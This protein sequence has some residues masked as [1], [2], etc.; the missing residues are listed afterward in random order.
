MGDQATTQL[1]IFTGSTVEFNKTSGWEQTDNYEGTLTQCNLKQ[2]QLAAS[3]ATRIRLSPKGNGAYQVSGTFPYNTVNPNGNFV[4]NQEL[5]TTVT[6]R[7]VYQ[8]PVYRKRFSDFEPITKYSARANAT[9]GMIA[10]VARKYQS[11]Q[12]RQEADFKYKWKAASFVAREQAIEQ[13]LADRL[14]AITVANGYPFALAANEILAAQLLFRNIAFRG[15]TSFIEYNSV[16]RRTVTSGSAQAVR[17][18]NTGAG[19]IWTTAELV[20]F[21]GINGVWFDIPPD[22]NWHKDKPRVLSAYGQKT[23]ISYSYTEIVTASWL[24]YEAHG[25]A[26]LIDTIA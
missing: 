6:M 4:D 1:A 11:G 22:A 8:S 26:V 5:E 13:E 14:A 10:D 2:A 12:P 18:N 17:A 25:G 16:F 3:G 19:K 7:S 9:L 21:E 20:A 15:V 24:E 23:Q